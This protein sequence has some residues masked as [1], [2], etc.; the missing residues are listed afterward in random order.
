M[1]QASCLSPDVR[2]GVVQPSG[3]VIF[4][5]C[6]LSWKALAVV[7]VYE[8]RLFYLAEKLFDRLHG[9]C[10]RVLRPVCGGNRWML[11]EDGEVA[12]GSGLR[13]HLN[14]LSRCRALSFDYCVRKRSGLLLR[15]K[16]Q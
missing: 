5:Q 8:G 16:V 13:C 7:L 15:S 10:A 2:K 3:V 12:A 9:S 1:F 11:G 4:D 14:V 6:E